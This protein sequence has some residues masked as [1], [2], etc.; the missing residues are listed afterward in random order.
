MVGCTNLPLENIIMGNIQGLYPKTNQT[1]V[2]FLKELAVVEDPIFIALTE[3]HL[4][5]EVN[6]AEIH[7]ENYSPFRVERDRRKCG[8][9]I[10]YIRDDVSLETK[11]MLSISNGQVEI[12]AVHL[13]SKNIVVINCYRPPQ[14]SKQN[15]NS[16]M[17][18]VSKMIEDL[19]TPTPE[20]IMCGDFNFPEIKWPEGT[21]LAGG[22]LDHQAQAKALLEVTD[23]ALLTQQIITPTRRDNILDLYF[24]NNQESV[25]TYRTEKNIFSDH[26]L[27]VVNTAYKKNKSEMV[28]RNATGS[29]PFTEFNFFSEKIEWEKLQQSI[30]EVDWEQTMLNE[31]PNTMLCTLLDKLL[32]ICRLHIPTRR[33]RKDNRSNIP[34]NR[35][36]LMRKRAML[37]KKLVKAY[38]EER[39]RRIDA[40]LTEIEQQLKQSHTDQRAQEEGKAINK[41][42]RNPKFF[43]S[44]CKRYS[45]IKTQIGPLKDNEGNIVKD[46]KQTADLLLQQYNSVFSDPHLPKTVNDPKEVSSLQKDLDT[47]YAWVAS[48]YMQ[49]NE[50]KFEMVRHGQ[51]LN[52]KNET[53]LYTEGGQEISALPHAKCLEPY[54]TDRAGRKVTR[55]GLP[56]RAPDRIRTLLSNSLTYDGPKSFNALPKEVRSVT[57][58][59]VDNF[60]SGLD[61]F[62]YTIPD[63]PPVLGYTARCRTSNT[64]PDQVTLQ[65]RDA[66]I[67][68]SSG[69]LRL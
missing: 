33:R 66:R 57:G 32:Q 30:S 51:K 44:Y 35:K 15:F 65:D 4:H 23:K 31:D 64:I 24:T 18:G 54:T 9:V 22:T 49:F 25:N 2:L 29:S 43:Y 12:I 60:K 56:T 3:T 8:G 45:K 63:E 14:A 67:G 41:I 58:C 47:V 21:L 1:K 20:I 16:A 37:Y 62:L 59:S 7:I 39:K 34:R 28:E 55:R 17:S 52:L 68:S 26:N 19:S 13:A 46:P 36:I 40:K 5:S 61:K 50:G 53:K 42:K 38:T 69:P 48:N 10:L 6:N 11:Q 27:I